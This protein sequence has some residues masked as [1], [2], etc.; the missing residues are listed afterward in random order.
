MQTAADAESN[1]CWP[2]NNKFNLQWACN[3][4]NPEYQ[5]NTVVAQRN[6]VLAVA[7]VSAQIS[8]RSLLHGSNFKGYDEALN[9]V[10]NRSSQIPSRSVLRQVYRLLAEIMSNKVCVL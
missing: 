9:G 8:V 5:G 1:R 3:Q 2:E 4:L 10:I 7:L 6:V